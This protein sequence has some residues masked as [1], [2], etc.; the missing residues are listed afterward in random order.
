MKK[1]I[2]IMVFFSICHTM[3]SY[4]HILI[5]LIVLRNQ[6]ENLSNSF[7]FIFSDM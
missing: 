5:C 1:M 4:I 6:L 2:E 3:I 7:H